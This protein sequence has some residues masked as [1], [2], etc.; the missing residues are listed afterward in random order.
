M[1]GSIQVEGAFV[2]GLGW[3]ALEEVKWGDKQHLW[4][5]PGHL[6]TQ[7]PGTYKLPTANDIP[8]E[9]HVSLLKVTFVSHVL[10]VLLQDEWYFMFTIVLTF[11]LE[12]P[13]RMPQMSGPSTLQRLWESHL[14]SLHLRYFLP[15]KMPSFQ[16]EKSTG[17]MVSLCWIAL[18]HLKES[19]W[20]VQICS[21]S[22]LQHLILGRN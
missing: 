10:F 1:A 7:G 12:Y 13:L 8:G 9:F 11:F 5:K 20:L 16:H 18:Q 15:L 3:V 21:L 22:H 17:I 14:C 6:Y 2:Q 4:V 19:E